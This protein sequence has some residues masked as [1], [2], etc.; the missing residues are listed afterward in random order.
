M[1]ATSLLKRSRPPSKYA[2]SETSILK[3]GAPTPIPH[4][5]APLSKGFSAFFCPVTHDLMKDPVMTDDGQTYE[6]AVSK[7]DRLIDRVQ[8]QYT[9]GW[10]RLLSVFTVPR[11]RQIYF[12]LIIRCT[13]CTMSFPVV[14]VCRPLMPAPHFVSRQSIDGYTQTDTTRA[15][16]QAHGKTSQKCNLNRN[17]HCNNNNQYQRPTQMCCAVCEIRSFGQMFN[18]AKLSRSGVSPVGSP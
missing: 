6:R 1:V 14:P 12:A 16:P 17:L 11:A 4:R 8:I 7:R 18:C 2:K 3:R 9:H 15:H 13:T 10:H 5:R